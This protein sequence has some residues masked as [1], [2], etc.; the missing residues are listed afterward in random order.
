M[1]ETEGAF[2]RGAVEGEEV[3]LVAVGELAVAA[4]GVEVGVRELG[5]GFVLVFLVA[6][7]GHG[8]GRHGCGG[9][10]GGGG[11]SCT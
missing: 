4:D 5:K 7:T 10:C 11:G 1:V 6:R 9:G 8:D 3:E 2:A